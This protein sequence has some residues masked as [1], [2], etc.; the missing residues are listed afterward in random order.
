MAETVER[1]AQIGL[2]WE[3]VCADPNLDDLPYKIETN[4]WG[5][6]VMSP[7]R[8]KH[9]F[10]QFKIGELLARLLL[11]SGEVITE[12]AIKTSKGTKV[13]DVAW[14]SSERWEQVKDEFDASVA[15]EIC[16]EILSPRNS[17]DEIDL[18][19]RLYFDAGAQEVWLCDEAGRLR[20]FNAE[21]ELKRSALVPGFPK[22]VDV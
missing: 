17:K 8:L 7:T 20:F 11:G 4:E 18:K 5:Q 9:G 21:T 22:Q 10:F 2:T 1:A 12:A 6:I 16:V 19:K 3:E 13:A 14:F 15:P